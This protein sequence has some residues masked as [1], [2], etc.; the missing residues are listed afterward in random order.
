MLSPYDNMLFVIYLLK[1]ILPWK[2]NMITWKNKI[3]KSTI[4]Y[5][6][7][8]L[9]MPKTTSHNDY[10]V[11]NDVVDEIKFDYNKLS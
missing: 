1:F 4:H 11:G 2:T 9:D 7:K 5:V 3:W 6:V 8:I 10:Q